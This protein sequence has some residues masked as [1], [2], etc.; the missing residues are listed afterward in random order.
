MD[1]NST[2]GR[3]RDLHVERSYLEAFDVGGSVARFQALPVRGMRLVTACAA[4]TRLRSVWEWIRKA[5]WDDYDEDQS[6]RGDESVALYRILREAILTSLEEVPAFGA[7][8]ELVYQAFPMTYSAL[9]SA[10]ELV[11][12]KDSMPY[13]RSPT[14]IAELMKWWTR[15][16]EPQAKELEDELKRLGA[17]AGVDPFAPDVNAFLL[18]EDAIGYELGDVFDAVR[19]TWQRKLAAMQPKERPSPI[20]SATIRPSGRRS[21]RPRTSITY[22]IA[23]H[24]WWAMRD[25]YADRKESQPPTQGELCQRLTA[26]GYAVGD[27]TL[28]RYIREWRAAEL[29]WPPPRSN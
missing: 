27:R 23:A 15:D 18:A 6:D 9:N 11:S 16:L 12:L 21:G 1:D 2:D 22:D 10:Y 4:F 24:T 7:A 8:Y 17:Q 19:D 3:D 28:R 26:Q 29:P 14:K 20:S 5:N 25:E 13:H